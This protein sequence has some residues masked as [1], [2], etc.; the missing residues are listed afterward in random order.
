MSEESRVV[1]VCG[2]PRTGTSVVA[3]I[4]SHLGVRFD[5]G[6]VTKS[7]PTGSFMDPEM[8]FELRRPDNLAIDRFVEK[9]NRPGLSGFKFHGTT[10]HFYPCLNRLNIWRTIE[11]TR[12]KAPTM[13]SLVKK[14]GGDKGA[15]DRATRR[16]NGCKMKVARFFS[17]Y[18]G[19]AVSYDELVE[20]PGKVVAELASWLEVDATDALIRSAS[21]IV[22][23]GLRHWK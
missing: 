18:P 19:L 20:T 6:L 17:Q 5:R 22:K 14:R 12:P 16:Y 21:A 2:I 8:N 10:G 15:R 4:V 23:T 11:T 9:H 3:A 1:V 13:K 7:T